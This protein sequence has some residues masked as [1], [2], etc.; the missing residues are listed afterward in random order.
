MGADMFNQKMETGRKGQGNESDVQCYLAKGNTDDTFQQ[1]NITLKAIENRIRKQNKALRE[2][3]KAKEAGEE[4]DVPLSDL[5]Y[6]QQIAVQAYGEYVTKPYDQEYLSYLVSQNQ[7]LWSCIDA[8]ARNSVG[9]G[10]EIRPYLYPHQTLTDFDENQK[11]EYRAQSLSL[12]KWLNRI[13][14]PGK[15]FTNVVTQQ[16]LNLVG[17]GDCYLEVVETL[18][19]DIKQ[20]FDIS[21]KRVWVGSN[22]DRYIQMRSGKKVYFKKF[23]DDLKRNKETFDPIES[24]EDAKKLASKMVHIRKPNL[25]SSVYGVTDFVPSIPNIV[26]ARSVDERNKVF[27]DNDGVPRLAITISGGGLT[28]DTETKIT[29]F[30][31]SNHKGVEN[32]HR[33]MVLAANAANTNSPNFRPPK[34]D[35]VPLTVSETEDG[36][37][38]KYKKTCEESIREAFRI[39]KIFL[40]TSEDVNRAAAFTMREMTVELVF[41][42]IGQMFADQYNET[43]LPEWREETGVSEE[44]C[45]VE[46]GFG[47]PATLT[48]KDKAEIT[49]AY[50][51]SGAYSPD[52]IREMQGLE[53][54]NKPWSKIPL[55][56]AIV[57]AQMTMIDVPDEAELLG[58]TDTSSEPESEKAVMRRGLKMLSKILKP[59]TEKNSHAGES[60]IINAFLEAD[61][62]AGLEDISEGIRDELGL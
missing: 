54:F 18:K 57:F 12:I 41:R 25:L 23:Q 42:V 27:F 33:I 61:K 10:L 46:I 60:A 30:L 28:E 50:A 1:K 2:Y 32:A 36:S 3:T 29:N 4:P 58:D 5:A 55:T 15:R 44:N 31:K 62:D 53:P 48:Q 14:G 40:G 26:G 19:G 20:I 16:A 47:V 11:Q 17:L 24:I 7:R 35:V 9:V 52:D 8:V 13:S 34:I 51:S 38:L 6:S 59:F 43:L 37:F 21:P 49:K 45:L 56:L 22:R 39:S